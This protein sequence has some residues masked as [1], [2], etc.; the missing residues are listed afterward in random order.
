MTEPS[1]TTPTT[2]EREGSPLPPWRF[3]FRPS[4]QRQLPE[5][6]ER[7]LRYIAAKS[8]DVEDVTLSL[9]PRPHQV[10]ED[11]RVAKV[12]KTAKRDCGLTA[13]WPAP[14]P[15]GHAIVVLDDSEPAPT[16]ENASALES[17]GPR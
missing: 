16:P 13:K 1:T 17:G 4:E 11:C 15:P 9:C 2:P 14:V 12:L 10:D 7:L 8:I 6:V 3:A 5:R